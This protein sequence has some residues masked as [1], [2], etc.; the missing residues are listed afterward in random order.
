[1]FLG[2][3]IFIGSISCSIC[4]E[5]NN[6]SFTM[7]IASILSVLI[8]ISA[9]FLDDEMETN[10]YALHVSNEDELFLKSQ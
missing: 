4:G 1:M 7:I 2:L 8:L 5:Y 6:E 10:S 3:G 9:L